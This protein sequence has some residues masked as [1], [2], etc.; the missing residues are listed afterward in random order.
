MGRDRRSRRAARRRRCRDDPRA[1]VASA[2]APGPSAASP[3]ERGAGQQP[4]H[5]RRRGRAEAAAERDPVGHR[6][7]PAQAIGRARRG[8]PARPRSRRGHE[9]VRPVGR[10]LAGALALDVQLDPDAGPGDRPRPRSG[11]RSRAPGRACRSRRR[12]WRWSPGPRRRSGAR[13]GRR[14]CSEAPAECLHHGGQR[15]GA[16]VTSGSASAAGRVRVLEAV[17]GQHADDERA[18]VDAA[19]RGEPAHARRRLAARGGL[20]E[21]ALE[22][23]QV[24]VRGE[25]LV[26]GDRLDE[27]ARLVAGARSPCSHEAGLPIRIAVAIVSGCSTG[28]PSTSGAA[29]AAWKPDIRGSASIEPGGA[30]V[31]EAHPVGADVAGVADRDREEVGRPP[32]VLADLERGGLL[33]LEPV[34]VDRVDERDRVL[35]PA[36][37][38][39]RTIAQRLVEVAVDGEHPRAG[40]L[41]LEQLAGRDLALGQDDDDLEPGRR[42]VRGRRGRGVAGGGADDRP[43]ALLERLGDGHDHARGP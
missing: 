16:A 20:A 1:R 39:S 27:P 26:V 37:V 38:S 5:G 13:R 42:A 12:G 15:S 18:R 10:Q 9:A 43:G 34:R 29:P 28:W 14:G 31:A 7:P 4:G 33:A 22:A 41:R 32:Q 30:V 2:A 24:T 21:D 3:A 40:G 35:G 36:P 19:R 6:D 17:P 8:P 23:R 11:R 25:D